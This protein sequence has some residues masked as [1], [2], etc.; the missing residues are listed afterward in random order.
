MLSVSSKERKQTHVEEDIF[1]SSLKGKLTVTQNF[2]AIAL[3]CFVGSPKGNLCLDIVW[4]VCLL[5]YYSVCFR[6]F[7]RSLLSENV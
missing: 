4:N 3:I 7:V 5:E 2:P 6:T 1:F